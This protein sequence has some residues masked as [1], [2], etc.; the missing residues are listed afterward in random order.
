MWLDDLRQEELEQQQENKLEL[1]E[2]YASTEEQVLI[3]LMKLYESYGVAPRRCR[4]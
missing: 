4:R 1:E 2:K 3:K